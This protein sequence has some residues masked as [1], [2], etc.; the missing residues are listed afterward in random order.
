M[1]VELEGA[2]ALAQLGAEGSWR[3]VDHAGDLHGDGGG[4]RDDPPR[5]QIGPGG[6]NDGH[7]VDTGVVVEEAVLGGH[8]RLDE[9]GGQLIQID[10][11]APLLIGW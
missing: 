1:E 2:K 10:G 7:R 9:L 5:A 8:H 3:W 11:E 4:A 6:A